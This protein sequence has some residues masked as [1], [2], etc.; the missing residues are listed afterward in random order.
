M[1]SDMSDAPERAEKPSVAEVIKEDI[2]QLLR[3]KSLTPALCTKLIRTLEAARDLL[4]AQDDSLEGVLGKRRASTASF[5]SYGEVMTP[6][7]NQENFGSL[8]G[9]ELIANLRNFLPASD[10]ARLMAALATAKENDMEEEARALKTRLKDLLATPEPQEEP[11]TKAGNGI[12]PEG[13]PL[14][15]ANN[16]QETQ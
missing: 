2:G 15:S 12:P 10:P 16:A 7:S 11:E 13:L 5:S 1:I 6:S 9:R 4:Q 14:A 3:E 8:I